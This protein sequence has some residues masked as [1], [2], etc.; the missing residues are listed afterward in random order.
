MRVSTECVF[1]PLNVA[2][3]HTLP[4]AHVGMGSGVLHVIMGIGAAMGTTGTVSL[5]G[6]W[7]HLRSQVAAF[8]QIFL[9]ISLLSLATIVPALLMVPPKR[10]KGAGCVTGSG[11][12]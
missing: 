2:A 3:L 5:L 4:E 8:Q 1:S 11:Q 10:E 7:T 12:C 9:L 6:H